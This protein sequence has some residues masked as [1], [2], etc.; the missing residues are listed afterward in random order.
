M[1]W[2][3]LAANQMVSFT[4]AQG[5]GFG[6]NA[7]QSHVTSEQCMTKAEIIAK[8]NVSSASMASYANNQLVPK[9]A[10][11]TGTVYQ[12]APYSESATKNNCTGTGTG[13]SVTLYAYTGQFT[14]TSTQADADAQAVTWVQANKQSYANTNGYCTWLSIVK[15]GT[16]TR[17]NCGA[18]YTGGS[19]TYTVVANAYSSITSQAAADA[20]AQAD[21]D[22]YGQNKVNGGTGG[23]GTATAGTCTLSAWYNV[24]TSGNFTR[25]NCGAD[26]TGGTGTYTVPANAYRSTVSQADANTSAQNDVNANG[27]NWINT[28]TGGGLGSATAGS[29]TISAWYNIIKSGSFT[30]NNCGVAY[31]GGSS[32]YTVA[33]GAYRSI[34]SQAD[35]D[36]VAQSHVDTYGQA[37]VNGT[38]GGLGTASAGSCTLRTTAWRVQAASSTCL[39]D[40]GDR[41][42]GYR[43]YTIL[44]QYYTD[45]SANTGTTK[46]NSSGDGDYVAPGYDVTTCPLPSA[47]SCG[48]EFD[49]AG[50]YYIYEQEVNVGANSGVV[51]I[52][53][54]IYLPSGYTSD[55]KISVQYEGGSWVEV[56]NLNLVTGTFYSGTANYSYTHNSSSTL[57]VKIEKYNMS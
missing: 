35:A 45:N 42:T 21:V 4:D 24:V 20:L 12:S 40:A 48:T 32:T 56:L 7:S 43:Y 37:A 52:D 39:L 9:Q 22:T 10:W 41:N 11:Q 25:S 29:C 28:G 3:S 31:N 54:S 33:A 36:A 8:Y 34:V 1:S 44:E 27:Q 19:S 53:Y 49:A 2:A 6:L 16:F 26:Y 38:P 5:S 30:R 14:S 55:V 47:I 15:S 13:S 18:D 17:T 23:L 46:A 51:G 57:K 50:Y